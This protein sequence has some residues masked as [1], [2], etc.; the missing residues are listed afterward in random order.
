MEGEPHRRK[1]L[2][3]TDEYNIFYRLPLKRGILSDLESQV[4]MKVLGGL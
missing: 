4:E 1:S 2:Q 3:S